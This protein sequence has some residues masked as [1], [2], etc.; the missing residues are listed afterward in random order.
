MIKRRGLSRV[1]PGWW[2]VLTAGFLAMW[3]HGYTSYGLSALFKPMSS[4]L[5]LSRA[6]TSGVTS[7]GR[8]EGGIVGP[9]A[10]W[11]TDRFGSRWIVLFGVFLFGLSLILM[12]F[13]NSLWAFYIVWGVMLGTGV[14]I[15]ATIPM[16][17][18]IA[19][20]FV[21]K[22]G[23][24]QG[25]RHV[26]S[27]LSG[28]LVLP[29]VAWL[30]AIQDW[31]MACVVG[32]VIMWLVGLPLTW[33]FVKRHRPEYYGLLPDGST[34]KEE[35]TRVEQI[36]DKGVEYAAE[37]EE[38]EF[39]LRQA[40]KTPVYWLLLG[41]LAIHS[42]VGPTINLH[43]IPFLTDI[44]IDPLRAAGIMA[45]TS[46]AG[47]P[48]RFA[49]GFLADLVKRRHIRFLLGAVYF[50]QAVGITIFLLKPSI[51]TI[52]VWLVLY[53]AG[54]GAA[55]TLSSLITARYFGR[56]A[57]GSIRGFSGLFMVPVGIVAPVYAG[58]VYDTTGS[59]ITSF[60]LFAVMLA[61]GTIL[62]FLALPPRPPAQITDVHRIV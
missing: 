29:F 46:L 42:A 52:Y 32:G 44:G 56:K 40:M 28:V 61:F 35:G 41:A 60:T 45:I 62:A 5:G 26:I 36:I 16:D 12:Y 30:L 48:A 27:G 38:V 43:A 54:Y 2:T 14:N 24:A 57:F 47:I 31:R 33:F 15:A 23:L 10:G 37:V 9:L 13:V 53:N 11:I 58:W 55:W 3:G 20:W 1:F 8:L 22:R 4:E 21:K 50:V 6:I 18:A 51:A 39:T 34:V 59:Y 7:I 49:G 17:A 19:N 25:I